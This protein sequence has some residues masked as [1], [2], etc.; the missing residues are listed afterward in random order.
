MAFHE[1]TRNAAENRY[2]HRDFHN[3]L[4][5]GLDYLYEHFGAAAVEEYLRRFTLHFY[6]P[7]IEQVKSSGFEALVEIFSSSFREENALHLLQFEQNDRELLVKVHSCPA[8]AHIHQSGYE[9]SPC[10]SMTSSVIWETIARQAGLG[11]V[12]LCYEEQTGRANHLFFR[13]I[14]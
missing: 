6:K 10:F 8:V 14:F 3:I 7:L 13:P 1:M 2:F 5:L 11:Y 12:M 4:N 9:P